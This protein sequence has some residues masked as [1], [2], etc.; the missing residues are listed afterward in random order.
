VAVRVSTGQSTAYNFS[1][2]VYG[3]LYLSH[4]R[5]RNFGPIIYTCD[6]QDFTWGGRLS[7]KLFATPFLSQH[8][9]AILIATP[10]S[11]EIL[12]QSFTHAPCRIYL[13]PSSFLQTFCKHLS[14]RNTFPQHLSQHRHPLKFWANQLHTWLA[15][16]DLLFATR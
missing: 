2:A 3:T 5:H 4:Q 15:A 1:Q 12:G 13:G 6:L 10:P 16:V 11:L 9:S 7:H 8:F 14:F